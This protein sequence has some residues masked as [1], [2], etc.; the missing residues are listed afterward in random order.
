MK[1][2]AHY[3]YD[4]TDLLPKPLTEKDWQ[5]YDSIEDYVKEFINDTPE[6]LQDAEYGGGVVKV[7]VEK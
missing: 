4:V 1:I 6:L 5:G 3:S 2:I 7:E